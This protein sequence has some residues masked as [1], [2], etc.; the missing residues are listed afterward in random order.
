M[1]PDRLVQLPRQGLRHR[2]RHGRL[3]ALPLLARLYWY[4]IEFGLVRDPAGLRAYGAGLLSSGGELR[5]CI[6][7]PAPLRE[8]LS[9][10][11]RNRA[12]RVLAGAIVVQLVAMSSMLATVPYV[13]RYLLE[14]GAALNARNT[15]GQ[16]PYRIALGIMVTQMFFSHPETAALLKDA[17]GI[18]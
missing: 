5:H 1:A 15:G 9:A 10:V 4:T 6:D 2:R 18:E 13:A 8:Q 14:R 16:T 7:S 11:L 3:G 17:G 12:F